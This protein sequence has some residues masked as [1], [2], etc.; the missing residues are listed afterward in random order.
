M[1]IAFVVALIAVF[2]S[3]FCS[4]HPHSCVWA[5]GEGGAAMAVEGAESEMGEFS[6]E[7]EEEEQLDSMDQKAPEGEGLITNETR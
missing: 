1:K 3:M 2:V 7:A 5:S 4:V 6:R